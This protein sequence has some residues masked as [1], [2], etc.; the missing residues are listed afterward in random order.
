MATQKVQPFGTSLSVQGTNDAP[1]PVELLDFFDGKG[2]DPA[3]LKKFYGLGKSTGIEPSDED[4]RAQ[5][6]GPG[7]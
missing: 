3:F 4:V 2:I 7:F 6:L 5:L 1:I